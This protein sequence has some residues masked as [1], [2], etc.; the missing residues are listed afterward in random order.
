[1]EKRRCKKEDPKRITGPCVLDM[2]GAKRIESRKAQ[3][4]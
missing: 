3:M 1:V 4:D 2:E